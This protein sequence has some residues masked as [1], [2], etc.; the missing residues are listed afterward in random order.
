M[1]KSKSEWM[2]PTVIV[3]ICGLFISVIWN[4]FQY[5]QIQTANIRADEQK[6]RANDLEKQKDDY[7]KKL[8]TQLDGVNEQIAE[9]NDNLR[10]AQ[11][12]LQLKAD[13]AKTKAHYNEEE[14]KQELND[15]TIE[16]KSLEKQISDFYLKIP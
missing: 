15:L 8:N 7:V 12:G 1:K 5:Q 9:E 11:S 16:K 2:S 10:F 14:S 4:V 3:A 13:T 6:E